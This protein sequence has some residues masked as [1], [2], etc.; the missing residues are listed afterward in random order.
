MGTVQGSQTGT[1]TDVPNCH[2]VFGYAS[3]LAIQEDPWGT[4]GCGGW[5][6]EGG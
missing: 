3:Y 4:T 5:V 2:F 1:L 6:G